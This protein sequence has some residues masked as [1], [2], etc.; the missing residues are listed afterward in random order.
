[1]NSLV[2][3]GL[4]AVAMGAGAAALYADDSTLSVSADQ[5][6]QARVAHVQ[7]LR[8][9]G[10]E[11]VRHVMQLREMARRAKDVIRLNCVNDK[12][13]QMQPLMNTVDRLQV[14]VQVN[15]SVMGEVVSATDAVHHL[16]DE[17]DG[18]GGESLLSGTESANGF[19][20][21]NPPD[22]PYGNPWTATGTIIEP[23]GYASP[24]N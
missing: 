2:K 19:T 21:P 16:R 18:C 7:T 14:D 22:N 3:I 15:P 13:V 20:A 9:R 1:M 4:F 17:A 11:D 24:F 12:L 6:A 8:A 5:S 23:P 10:I